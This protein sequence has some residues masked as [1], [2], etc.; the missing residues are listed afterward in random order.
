MRLIYKQKRQTHTIQ[1]QPIYSGG[2]T[3]V[4]VFVITH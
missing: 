3:Q 2:F 1:I 4:A